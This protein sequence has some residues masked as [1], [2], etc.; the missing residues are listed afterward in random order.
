MKP[1]VASELSVS[2]LTGGADRPYAFGLATALMSP[3]TSIDLIGND[4]LDCPEFRNPAV[5]FLNFRGDQNPNAG[6]ARKAFR[7]LVYYSRL[8]GYAATAKPKLFH[9]LWNNKF[10]S[11]DRTV[12][13]LYYKC[14]GKRILLTS[15][16]VNTRKRD[17]ND[18]FF[19]R[20][21]L[22]FQYRLADHVFVHTGKMKAE[23]SKELGVEQERI[24]VIPFGINN[25]VPN[26]ELTP[27]EARR[28]LGI[29]DNQK[30]ILFF[31]NITPY[32]GLEYLVSAF[33]RISAGRGDYRLII[34]GR[35][36]N[37]EGYWQPIRQDLAQDIQKG[38]I[39]LKAHH[40]PD[41]ETEIYFKAADLFALPYRHIYQSGVLF[42]G[43]SF[44]LPVVAADVGSL[45]DEIVEGKTGFVCKPEDPIDLARAIQQYFGSDLYR[46]LNKRRQQIREYTEKNHSW[47]DVARMTTR[48]YARLLGLP[49][50]DSSGLVSNSSADFET[51]S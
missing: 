20:V 32:K 26:T 18:S 42:L 44:G 46:D 10:E 31:G 5:T 37:C 33:R 50:A 21:T 2:L 19:N 39:L 13:M 38:R 48:V 29:G 49:V 47:N 34:A 30:T 15:H 9:I 43:Q 8:I 17:S 14:L 11:F 7:V 23:L 1:A 35:P 36:K 27:S 4:D 24:T 51:S 25:S 22:R 28:R 40:I 3:R 45:K 41:N 12:L 16:N 6:F